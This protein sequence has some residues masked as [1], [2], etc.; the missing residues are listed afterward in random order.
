MAR[1]VVSARA[2]Q[3]DL[4]SGYSGGLRIENFDFEIDGRGRHGEKQNQRNDDK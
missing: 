2:Q 3:R 1:I 4:R